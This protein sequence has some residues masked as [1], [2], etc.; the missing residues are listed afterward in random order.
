MSFEAFGEILSTVGTLIG[1]TN[2][3]GSLTGFIGPAVV[4]AVTNG[5]V[6]II[7]LRIYFGV[8]GNIKLQDITTLR[9]SFINVL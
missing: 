2:T 5:N 8:C 7:L 9:D 3:L 1:I 4:G 6:R